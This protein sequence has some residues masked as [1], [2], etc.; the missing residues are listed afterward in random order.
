MEPRRLPPRL[1]MRGRDDMQ[2]QAKGAP[3]MT[4]EHRD[5]LIAYVVACLA[6]LAWA[7]A[8]VL[9]GELLDLWSLS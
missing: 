5:G 3:A 8:T 6:N 9:I 7:L 4:P 2:V 1:Y